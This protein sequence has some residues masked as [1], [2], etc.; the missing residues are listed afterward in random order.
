MSTHANFVHLRVHTA[1]SL[2][3]G[4]IKMKELIGLTKDG[5]FPAVAVTDFGNMFG[6][7]EFSTLTA[8]AGI[9]PLIGTV[10]NVTP[11]TPQL[12]PK[13][14]Y[15]SRYEKPDRVL[16][17]AQNDPGYR[18]LLKMVSKAYVDSDG[19]VPP[20]VPF[21]Y[22]LDHHDGLILLIGMT[23][24]AVGRALLD[25]DVD[26]AS[27]VL[28][29]MSSA[30]S[31]RTYVEI[32]RHGTVDEER[33]EEALIDLAYAKDLPLVATNDAYFG[34]RDMYEAHDALIC[35]REGV[36]LNHPERIR[37][38]PEHYFKSAEDMRE[39]F[40]DL[41][42]AC[43]NT[44]V[45]AQRCAFSVPK[46]PPILPSY[47][48]GECEDDA[49]RTLATEGLH[50]RLQTQVYW[51]EMT[52]E[53]KQEIDDKYFKRLEYELGIII[54]MKFPGYFLIVA[55]FIQWSKDN[56][57]P[58]GPGRGSGAGS[59]V[60]WSLTITDLDPLRFDLLFERFLNPERVSM[61]DFDIDFCQDRR[62][63]TIQYVQDRYG[64]DR[65]AQ[66]ITFGKLQARAVLRDV[67]RV[68]GMPFGQTDKISKLVPNNPAKPT[69][70][71][72]AING[73]PKLQEMRDNDP[74]VAQLF[75]I[76]L[77][78]EGLYRNASTHAAGVVI[79]DRPLDE[80]VPL[81][82]DPRS[83]MPATQFNMAWVET[84]GLV[85]FDFLGLKTLTVLSTAVN[86]IAKRGIHID[87][88]Q[89]PLDDRPTYEMLTRGDTA[90]VFQ[91]ESQ[92][93]RDV[94]R[95][96]HPDS[97]EDIVAVVALYRP[98]PMDN[99]PSYIARK[100]GQE[101]IDYMHDLIKPVLTETYGIIIYQEQVMQI[102]QRMANYS[103]GGADL[104]RRAMGKK[105]QEEMD[106]QRQLFIA[107]SAENGVDKNMANYIFDHVN[108]FA[109]YGF[110]K[111]HAA[112][113]ALVAYQ[114]AYL[115]ANYPVEFLAASMTLDIHNT[116]KLASFKQELDR[117]KIPVLM[118]DVNMSEVVFNVEYDKDGKGMVRYALSALKNVGEAAMTSLVQ[119]RENGGKYQSLI[120]FA[121]RQ[122]TH[123]INKRSLE[124]LVRAGAFDCL[125]SN[126]FKVFSSLEILVKHAQKVREEKASAQ[127]SMFGGGGVEVQ[128]PKLADCDDWAA[129]DRLNEE[130]G[131]IGFYLSAHPL[132]TY[133][134]ITER[135]GVVNAADLASSVAVG[136]VT[137]AKLAGITVNFR[138]RVGKSGRRYAFAEFSD[139][140]GSYEV[141]IFSEVLERAREV[142]QSNAPLL[143]T[144]VVKEEDGQLRMTTQDIVSLDHAAAKSV[145]GLRVVLNTERPVPKLKAIMDEAPKGRH[146]IRVRVL[147]DDQTVDL[148][149]GSRIM[150]TQ[151]TM[152]ALRAVSGILELQ[153]L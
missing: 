113:Y 68:L 42:E 32:Q 93:M 57:I 49:L 4:A 145:K 24:G 73:E 71:G 53:E 130:F 134:T 137:R 16:L 121:E 7:L 65:V 43:D 60:A 46:L 36:T 26:E 81:Y 88:S 41:P 1:Y 76:G 126:R 17:L 148:K 112:A 50:K 131:A 77:K 83:E 92:G 102:A 39:L 37:F 118:P 70:L 133:S 13:T 69:P 115:K 144:V 84:A 74:Q 143:L 34:S 63:E 64:H 109:G 82:K 125:D 80:L 98:G 72:E 100:H 29:L 55:D 120:N 38:T 90:G 139:A 6:A 20:Q 12:D 8:G 141:A 110:N 15:D 146:N 135:L 27:A 56:D 99:I 116:D 104:L 2:A 67:G 103:L 30:Y 18:N 114:T 79:G 75:D 44:L 86:L 28:D 91:L 35:I 78:L 124:N 149:L 138:E 140:T 107:G 14:G 89:I 66:I 48:E 87:L 21:D 62:E 19:T 151:R 95:K 94:L 127:V 33:I 3:T 108:K 97:L 47:K 45:I 5:N 25:D 147:L 123:A 58:V 152:E 106:K 153:E 11:R 111:S 61:P 85:K 101:E 40:S 117:L 9:Q 59:V 122:D 129:M 23:D 119:E 142:I 132:D 105:K 31:G 128:P 10:L 150:L 22:F 51:P 52:E 54:N 136:G 96:L